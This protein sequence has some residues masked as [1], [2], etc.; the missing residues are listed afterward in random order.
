METLTI[1]IKDSNALK[2]IRSLEA[3]NVLEVVNPKKKGS[4]VKLSERLIGSITPEQ[5]EI[6]H[7]EVQQMRNEWERDIY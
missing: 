5:A 7:K 6:M 2:L 4:A 3:L 1:K